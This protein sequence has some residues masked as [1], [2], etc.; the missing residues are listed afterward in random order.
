MNYYDASAG[1]L[2][3][4]RTTTMHYSN[5]CSGPAYFKAGAGGGL[6]L[7]PVGVRIDRHASLWQLTPSAANAVVVPAGPV[8]VPFSELA[9][10]GCIP[11]SNNPAEFT[12]Y[13]GEYVANLD[14]YFT[15]P[16]HLGVG[17]QNG[18]V[19]ADREIS[20]A[21]VFYLINFLFGGGPAPM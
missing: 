20:V 15:P 18:D 21:D 7:G 13:P 6:D 10:T 11:T 4:E 16:F 14:N 1:G 19:N 9:D 2:V 17:I 5:D 8:G 3:W 12:M